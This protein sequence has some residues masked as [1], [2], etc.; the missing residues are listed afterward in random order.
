MLEQEFKM[1]YH[2]KYEAKLPRFK[3]TAEEDLHLRSLRVEAAL[4]SLV[5]APTLCDGNVRNTVD[6][7][8]RSIIIIALGKNPRK[9]IKDCQ[10]TKL[11]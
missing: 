9:A 6:S 7:Q 4:K 10:R 1:G 8:A 2:H 5:L 11:A 3:W